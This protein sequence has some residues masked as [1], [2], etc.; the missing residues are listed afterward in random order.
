MKRKAHP[1]EHEAELN[2]IPYLDIMVNLVMFMLM[3]MTGFITFQMVN[4]NMPD[5]S[6]E[7]SAINPP[8]KS[9]DQNLTL[10]VSIS[11]SGFVIA[12]TGGVLPGVS[13]AQPTIALR[14]DGKYDFEALTEKMTAIKK[15]YPA[16]SQFFLAA[17]KDVKYDIIVQT[18]DATRGDSSH[19]LFPDVA[20][21]A[22]M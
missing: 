14:P 13:G 16:T 1:H 10:N 11:K 12:A 20:F 2:I 19:P 15:Q 18:M 3:S 9:A 7:G 17:D 8:P 6:P 21:A 4:V 22:V 5:L